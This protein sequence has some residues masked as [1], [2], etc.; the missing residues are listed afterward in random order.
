MPR[1]LKQEIERRDYLPG[2]FIGNVIAETMKRAHAEG[3]DK[4]QVRWWDMCE[5]WTVASGKVQRQAK[6]TASNSPT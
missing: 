6:S 5:G 1:I 2:Q 4:W 3:Y